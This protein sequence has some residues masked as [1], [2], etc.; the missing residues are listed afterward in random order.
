MKFKTIIVTSLVGF[1]LISCLYEKGGVVTPSDNT[2]G[3][4]PDTGNTTDTGGQDT[5]GNSAATDSTL[6]AICDLSSSSTNT[7]SNVNGQVCFDTEI[8]PLLVSNCGES[9]CHNSTTKKDGYDLTSYASIVR[10]GISAGNPNSSKIY[11]VLSDSGEDRMPPS[12]RASLTS[13]EKKLIA[14]WITQG[15]KEVNCNTST[16]GTGAIPAGTVV[17]F[18]SHVKPIIDMACTGCHNANSPSAGVNL[19]GY[20]NVKTHG[21]S[22]K[23]IGTITYAAGFLGMPQ[24]YKLTDCQIAAI[25]AW[26]DQGMAN[27]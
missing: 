27:N 19:S 1:T 15:A 10:K 25:S 20:A 16:G 18:T 3:T 17:S 5:T 2:S 6:N 26:V 12:P 9:G 11:T 23:L 7:T 21:A 22:G 8:L 13:A 4:N 24:G 14:D